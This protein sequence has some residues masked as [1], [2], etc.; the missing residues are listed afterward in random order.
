MQIC[1]RHFHLKTPLYHS[2]I[3]VSSYGAFQ[4]QGSQG[5]G[6]VGF[7]PLHL[8]LRPN[9][10]NTFFFFSLTQGCLFLCKTMFLFC[11]KST[12]PLPL[13]LCTCQC[14]RPERHSPRRRGLSPYFSLLPLRRQADSRW[15]RKKPWE[16]DFESSR[17][18]TV[19]KDHSRGVGHSC[20]W[21]SV[22]G[23][24]TSICCRCSH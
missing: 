18:G 8:S 2:E 14:P 22:P 6:G 12:P 11:T 7:C 24:V 3:H 16:K 17:C 20:D 21:N 15:K 1:L 4:E 5:P 13:P 19:G 9:H 10:R 23:Q